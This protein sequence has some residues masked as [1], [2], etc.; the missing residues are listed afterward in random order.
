MGF[1]LIKQPTM[2]VP[3]WLWFHTQITCRWCLTW[4]WT[5]TSL[6]LIVPSCFKMF[7]FSHR[8]FQYHVRFPEGRDGTVFTAVFFFFTATR[9]VQL[10]FWYDWFM[11]I[12]DCYY[13]T[14]VFGFKQPKA[15]HHKQHAWSVSFTQSVGSTDKLPLLDTWYAHILCIILYNTE[16]RMCI[17]YIFI[18]AIV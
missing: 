6:Q 17:L 5:I 18:H 3:A 10:N 16:L 7:P 2:G 9:V 8:K 13:A 1:S 11:C 15:A 14:T 12:Y 4:Q